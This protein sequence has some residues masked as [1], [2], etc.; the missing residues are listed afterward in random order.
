MWS[1]FLGMENKVTKL[2]HFYVTKV[3][4]NFTTFMMFSSK[5]TYLEIAKNILNFRKFSLIL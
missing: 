5:G 2:Q 4:Y 3:T 1:N